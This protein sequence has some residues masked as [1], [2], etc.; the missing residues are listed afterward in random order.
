LER[1]RRLAEALAL[2]AGLKIKS[3]DKISTMTR[4]IGPRGAGEPYLMAKAAS[5]AVPT[6][7][8]AGEEE[9]TAHIQAVF[10]VSP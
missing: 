7:I 9:I 6:P 4:I 8:E 3:V 5:P 10:L 2:A 1:A